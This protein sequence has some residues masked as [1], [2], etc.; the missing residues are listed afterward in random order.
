MSIAEDLMTIRNDFMIAHPDIDWLTIGTDMPYE[1]GEFTVSFTV[2]CQVKL[3]FE[4]KFEDIVMDGEPV[5]AEISYRLGEL[6]HVAGVPNL[7]NALEEVYRRAH[8]SA[9]TKGKKVDG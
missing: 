4:E 2:H 3:A 5:P 8:F 9:F 7:G 6:E 1:A